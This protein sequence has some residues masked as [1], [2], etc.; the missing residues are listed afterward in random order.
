M[1]LNNLVFQHSTLS[2]YHTYDIY[3][4]VLECL[5]KKSAL[6]GFYETVFFYLDIWRYMRYTYIWIWGIANNH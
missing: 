4:E 6:S 5:W 1:T 3:A 2:Y